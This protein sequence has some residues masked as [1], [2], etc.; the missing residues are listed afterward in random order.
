ML[1][2]EQLYNSFSFSYSLG[3]ET[4]IDEKDIGINIGDMIMM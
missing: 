3:K 4:K 2:S 1:G